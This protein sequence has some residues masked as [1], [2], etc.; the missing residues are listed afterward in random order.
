LL[1]KWS[2]EKCSNEKTETV[3]YGFIWLVATTTSKIK[4]YTPMN[5]EAMVQRWAGIAST[6]QVLASLWT[7]NF[8]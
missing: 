7:P 3:T 1:Q 8:Y 2:E 5:T 4:E 6:C